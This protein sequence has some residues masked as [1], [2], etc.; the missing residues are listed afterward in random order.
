MT[1]RRRGE[2]AANRIIA[3]LRDAVA[4]RVERVTT[5]LAPKACKCASADDCCAIE[6]CQ[7]S[8]VYAEF[9]RPQ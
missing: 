2:R 1:K 4:G 6:G 8:R 9:G 7:L 3:G 5:Y